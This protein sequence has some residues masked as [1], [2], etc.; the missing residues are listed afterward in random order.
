MKEHPT[1]KGYF[2][3]ED[4][5]V[6]TTWTR[7]GSYKTERE[8]RQQTGKWRGYS[9]I[10]IHKY[11]NASPKK[12]KYKYVHRLVAETY[13]PNPNNLPQVNHK[14]EDKTNN[15]VSNLE[16]CNHQYNSEYSLSKWYKIK[17]P[18]GE[19]VDVFNL[20]KFCLENN[21]YPSQLRKTGKCRGFML[22]H[23]LESQHVP[24]VHYS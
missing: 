11:E 15:H 23:S 17:T 5:K 21:L 7:Y 8:L 20:N 3:T 10:R 4:G 22:L 16:W 24:L 19:S 2:V 6:F 12:P 18:T 1:L 13:I 9:V 14:D